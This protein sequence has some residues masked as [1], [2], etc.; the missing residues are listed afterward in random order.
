MYVF[1]MFIGHELFFIWFGL[2]FQKN[3]TPHDENK[4]YCVIINK[5][6]SI[7]GILCMWSIE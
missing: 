4:F 7:A 5:N 3:T 1:L 2:V 6:V